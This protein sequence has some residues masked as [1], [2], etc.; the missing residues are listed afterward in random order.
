MRRRTYL[1]GSIGA[2][3]SL[4]GCAGIL[5][6][7]GDSESGD[8]GPAETIEAFYE[9]ALNGDAEAVRSYLH[10]EAKV[11]AP[12]DEEVESVPQS[13]LELEG[14]TVVE[15]GDDEATVEA[16][17]SE[18]TD[19]GERRERPVQFMLRRDDGEWKI[20]D[21]SLAGSEGSAVPQVVWESSE[22]TEGGATTAVVFEHGGGDTIDSS[23]LSATVT[24]STVDAP[25]AASEVMTGTAVV[26]PFGDGGEPLESGETVELVW[27]DPDNGTSSIIASFTLSSDTVGSPA[28]QLRIE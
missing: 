22:R 10:P 11:P 28:E 27:T 7:S 3:G 23:T 26:V 12:T 19:T 14:T 25:G 17:V 6:D 21:Q 20:Y 24:G 8:R 16:T 9:A 15:S 2:L 13:G 5:G 1:A 4:A 18:E